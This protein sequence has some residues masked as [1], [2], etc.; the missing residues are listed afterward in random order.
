MRRI[1]GIVLVFLAGALVMTGCSNN[2]NNEGNNTYQMGGSIQGTSLSLSGVVTT[3]AGAPPPTP[4]SGFVDGTGTLAR[5]N[6]PEN[7]TTDG[8]NIYVADYANHAIRK[9]VIATGAVTT[10]AGAPPTNPISGFADGTGALARFNNPDGIT[11]DGTNLYVADIWNLAIRKVVIA[12]G[13]VTTIAGAPPPT[14][15]S[16][17]VDDTGT[18]AR[19]AGPEGITTDGTNLYVTDTDNYGIRK[20]VIATGVVTTIAG[21][22]PPTPVS[23]FVDGTGTLARFDHPIGITTDGKNLY[24]GDTGNHAIRRIQ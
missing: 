5:F 1:A 12:T 13:A 10:I 4:V 21:A 8:T 17:F 22:R 20:V 24:V 9:I 23:G 3:I 6:N 2:D 19:F 7:I 14:P 15:V 11:T 18:L 16:G